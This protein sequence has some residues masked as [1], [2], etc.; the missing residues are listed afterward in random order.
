MLTSVALSLVLAPALATPPFPADPARASA[1]APVRIG[2]LHVADGEAPDPSDGLERSDVVQAVRDAIAEL[3]EKQRMALVLAK[4]E[5]MP[6]VEIGR[7]LGSSEKAI[8]SLI[9]R[10]RETLRERLSPFLSEELS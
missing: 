9:H 1:D 7:V 6:Y 3:P 5:D 10:A 4:Y 2:T 8:K